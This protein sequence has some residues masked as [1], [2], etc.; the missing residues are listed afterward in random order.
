MALV[1]QSHLKTFVSNGS[2][3]L[4]QW[5]SAGLIVVNFGDMLFERRMNQQHQRGELLANGDAFHLFRG[6]VK[7]ASS[8]VTQLSISTSLLFA[9]P[10]GLGVAAILAAA[11]WFYQTASS[12]VEISLKNARTH[13][14]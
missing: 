12:D 5:G 8:P 1:M 6:A 13:I 4:A 3:G 10:K 14:A 7:T 9:G 2:A 11:Q